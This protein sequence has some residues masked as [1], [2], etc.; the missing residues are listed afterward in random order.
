MNN[1]Q[2]KD[3]SVPAIKVQSPPLLDTSDCLCT[4]YKKVAKH[5]HDIS[6]S[7]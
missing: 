5:H 1:N 4:T 7:V 2:T 3:D 6:E